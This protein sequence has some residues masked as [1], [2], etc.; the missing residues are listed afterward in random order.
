LVSAK[1]RAADGGGHGDQHSVH[2]AAAEG[3][4]RAAETYARGRPRFPPEAREWLRSELRL[5]QGCTALDLSAGTGKFT[6]ELLS[7]GAT[8]VAVDRV[9]AML[10]QLRAAA[11][12]ATALPAAECEGV[13]DEVRSLI[14]ATPAL[15]G[16]KRVTLPYVTQAYRCSRTRDAPSGVDGR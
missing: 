2:R 15:A 13:L 9:A 7:T 14:A 5:G 16:A 8:V 4:A 10:D 11:P 12:G 3:F 6:V 1:A